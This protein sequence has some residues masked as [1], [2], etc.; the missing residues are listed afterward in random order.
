MTIMWN[1]ENICWN[2]KQTLEL[3]EVWKYLNWN[4]LVLK[5]ELLQK[6]KV[7]SIKIDRFKTNWKLV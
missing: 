5:T 7:K 2:I 1:V 4:Q 3:L 6:F